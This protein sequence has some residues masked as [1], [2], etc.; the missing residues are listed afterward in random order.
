VTARAARKGEL[1]V[2][3]ISPRQCS[4]AVATPAT[5]SGYHLECAGG[6]WFICDLYANS[7]GATLTDQRW[8]R[9]GVAYTVGDNR[10]SVKF[11]CSGST[12][13]AIGVYY[14]ENGVPFSETTTWDCT[15]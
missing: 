14:S 8:Y 5:A 2:Y 9:N 13:V 7:T 12:T 15:G 10:S 4:V 11:L 6:S 1:P 3:G